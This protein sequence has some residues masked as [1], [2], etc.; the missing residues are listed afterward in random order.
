M[1]VRALGWCFLASVGSWSRVVGVG[2]VCWSR[3]IS[4]NLEWELQLES[5]KPSVFARTSGTTLVP[6][7]PFF[8]LDCRIMSAKKGKTVRRT[9]WIQN[10]AKWRGL[11]RRRNATTIA[12]T[13]EYARSTIRIDV[14]IW[15][16]TP[17]SQYWTIKSAKRNP[18]LNWL[19]SRVDTRRRCWTPSRQLC[20][21][22]LQR[23]IIRCQIRGR[24]RFLSSWSILATREDNLLIRLRTLS[25]TGALIKVV[26]MRFKLQ[27]LWVH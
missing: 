19:Y 15:I 20:F 4:H 17:S 1:R 3:P 14:D 25:I 5:T 23:E 18:F 12:S 9:G 6:H 10:C 11:C 16:Y 26:K 2:G 22:A 24:Y 8:W 21:G 27:S 13:W 7:N